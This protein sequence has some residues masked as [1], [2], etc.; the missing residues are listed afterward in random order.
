MVFYFCSS[1]FEDIFELDE[2]RSSD[3]CGMSSISV[4]ILIGSVLILFYNDNLISS[5]YFEFN[6]NFLPLCFLNTFF[7][8]FF[9][10]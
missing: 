6:C 10:G 5:F 9:L 1:S 2:S 4:I 8:A 7:I 3:L